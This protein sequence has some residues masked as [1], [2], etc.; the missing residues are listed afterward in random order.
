VR[1]TAI[2]HAA[3]AAGELPPEIDPEQLDRASQLPNLT[4]SELEALLRLHHLA[5]C[6]EV[7]FLHYP[8]S[9][10]YMDIPG[11]RWPPDRVPP[12]PRGTPEPAAGM[13][14]WRE[15]LH[16]SIYT[17]LFLGA[18][19][20]RAYNE[21]FFPNELTSSEPVADHC[22][23][24]LLRAIREWGRSKTDEFDMLPSH[25]VYLSRLP[26]YHFDLVGDTPGPERPFAAL[27]RWLVSSAMRKARVQPLEARFLAYPGQTRFNRF[28]ERH[29]SIGPRW[30][31]PR[32]E[33]LS[34]MLAEEP[35]HVAAGVLW[36]VL[37]C[38][39]MSEFL[40]TCFEN[41]DGEEGQ[42]RPE[43]AHGFGDFVPEVKK[44]ADVVLFGTFR[45]ERVSTFKRS[46]ES[47]TR[48]FRAQSLRVE[49]QDGV[50]PVELDIPAISE[51][52]H[53][54]SGVPNHQRSH[55]VDYL[56]PPPPLQFFVS[57][58]S[59]H[60]RL[61]MYFQPN[62]EV[63][64]ITNYV[65]FTC[66]AAIFASVCLNRPERGDRWQTTS[67][68][69]QASSGTAFLMDTIR[70]DGDRQVFFKTI[71]SNPRYYPQFEEYDDSIFDGSGG[72]E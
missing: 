60:F 17:S 9:P 66:S 45:A 29:P 65:G 64:D 44:T 26:A 12:P 8:Y 2:V 27:E 10:Y 46:R 38:I 37:Q 25:S 5:R 23:L 53:M 52:L 22:R 50:P 39:H 6:V 18:A 62:Q 7:R 51:A 15:R 24:D 63:A 30:V 54:R 28:L 69:L 72:S 61:T 16:A 14:D 68:W 59:N 42:G 21:P 1:A 33:N 71:E 56:I 32:P 47:A 20:A 40:L 3:Q 36:V 35:A 4:R 43:S 13:P 11:G 55:D 49:P 41:V 57:L 58:L 19:L 70:L 48:P 67:S 34:Q 31:V